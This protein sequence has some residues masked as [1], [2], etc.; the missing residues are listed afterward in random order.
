[1]HNVT[2]DRRLDDRRAQHCSIRAS[3]TL[4]SVFASYKFVTYLLISATVST[5]GWKSSTAC[6]NV[7]HYHFIRLLTLTF[8]RRPTRVNVAHVR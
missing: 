1:M 7:S 4:I 5:V 8:W 2:D 6:W 3:D